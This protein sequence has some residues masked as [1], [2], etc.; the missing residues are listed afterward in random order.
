M[1][2]FVRGCH[3]GTYRLPGF[4]LLFFLLTFIF[5]KRGHVA[6]VFV[7]VRADVPTDWGAVPIAVPLFWTLR[8]LFL[9][10]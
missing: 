7:I 5:Q 2:P 3:H 10:L 8:L 6:F 4:I 1:D 9:T